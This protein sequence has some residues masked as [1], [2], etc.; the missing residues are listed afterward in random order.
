MNT[1]CP[2]ERQRATARMRL[3]AGAGAL[4][5][6]GGEVERM[7]AGGEAAVDWNALAAQVLANFAAT[8]QWY[9]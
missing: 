8:G 1:L 2:E 4:L 7:L 6:V 5:D 3:P 9:L